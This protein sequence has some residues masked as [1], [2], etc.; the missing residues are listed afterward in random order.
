MNVPTIEPVEIYSKIQDI[1]KIRCYHIDTLLRVQC[2]PQH[3]YAVSDSIPGALGLLYS[4][5]IIV[6]L[7]AISDNAHIPHMLRVRACI[8]DIE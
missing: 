2:Y 3:V 5:A 1:S 8:F 4:K 6:I 7:L